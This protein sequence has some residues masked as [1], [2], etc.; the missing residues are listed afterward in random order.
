[1]AKISNKR[2]DAWLN[3][4]ALELRKIST[5][6]ISGKDKRKLICRLEI[7]ASGLIVYKGKT[8]LRNWDWNSLVKELTKT[9]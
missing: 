2:R 5:I 1:M 4:D 9:K 8:K 7:N 3:I 6:K